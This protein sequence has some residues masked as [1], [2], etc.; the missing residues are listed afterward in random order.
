MGISLILGGSEPLPGWFG[1]LMQ[2]KLKFKWAF[3]GV[4]EGVQVCQETLLACWSS[5]Q[6]LALTNS[7][8]GE[9]ATTC[10]SLVL[11][12]YKLV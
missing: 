9:L 10:A 2:W 6:H 4:K 7:G 11:Q 3:A 8:P 1:A 12:T 5:V